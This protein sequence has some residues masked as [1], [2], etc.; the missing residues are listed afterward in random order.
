M[1]D[2][3]RLPALFFSIQK[4]CTLMQ[5]SEQIPRYIVCKERSV[6]TCWLLDGGSGAWEDLRADGGKVAAVLPNKSVEASG[7]T[8]N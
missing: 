4:L 1:R 2:R 7:V 3:L 5:F 8:Q 6:G